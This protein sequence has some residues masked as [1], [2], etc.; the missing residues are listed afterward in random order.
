[1]KIPIKQTLLY[2]GVFLAGYLIVIGFYPIMLEMAASYVADKRRRSFSNFMRSIGA[3]EVT[4]ADCP[5]CLHYH[6][7]GEKCCVC[8]TEPVECE[9]KQAEGKV[10]V[11]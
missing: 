7:D 9:E 8:G 3:V 4:K 6:R 2:I 11:Q 5:H 1:M 10:T